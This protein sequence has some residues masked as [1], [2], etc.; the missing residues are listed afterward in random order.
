MSQHSHITFNELTFISGGRG[1]GGEVKGNKAVKP[2]GEL[3][4]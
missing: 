1:D 2:L 3:R 4:V